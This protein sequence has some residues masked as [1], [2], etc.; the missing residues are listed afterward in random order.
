[1]KCP[2]CGNKERNSFYCIVCGKKLLDFRRF[3]IQFAIQDLHK[4]KEYTRTEIY[5]ILTENIEGTI[6]NLKIEEVE[7]VDQ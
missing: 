1:M 4:K 5:N 6:C 3:E 7:P 2:R